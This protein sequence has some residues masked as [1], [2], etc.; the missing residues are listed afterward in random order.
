MAPNS[1]TP[2]ALPIDLPN[3]FVPVTT[4]RSDQPTVACAAISVGPATK[5]RPAPVTK[6]APAVSQIVAC[7]DSNAVKTAP[8]TATTPPISAVVRNPARRY[9]RLDCDA[10]IG[11][12]SVMAATVK[13]ATSGPTPMTP[14]ANV[15]T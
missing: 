7:A 13:P 11:H 5:P 14:C 1:A 8:I 12:P 3:M 6:H 2:T 15:G 10:V 4:P 9:T